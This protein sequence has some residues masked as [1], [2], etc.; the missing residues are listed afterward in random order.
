MSYGTDALYGF[1]A[2]DPRRF[3]PEGHSQKNPCS[4]RRTSSAHLRSLSS[5]RHACGRSG[6][7]VAWEADRTFAA[8]FSGDLPTTAP[9]RRRSM[10][11]LLLPGDAVPQEHA[12]LFDAKHL[13]RTPALSGG[14]PRSW[15]N[16]FSN[17][18]FRRAAAAGGSSSA[19]R[20]PARSRRPRRCRWRVPPALRRCRMRPRPER[21][22]HTGRARPRS[23]SKTRRRCW[24]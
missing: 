16:T 13:S 20:R 15:P 4:C 21:P 24:R 14:R 8:R 6:S 10:K 17:G 11:T 18:N 1:A 9:S 7:H 22:L 5:R 23:W 12:G 3:T 2:H 19:R